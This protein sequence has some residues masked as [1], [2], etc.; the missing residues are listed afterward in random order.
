MTIIAH[1]FS[2]YIFCWP[3][4]NLTRWISQGLILEPDLYDDLKKTL[5]R[6]IRVL[7]SFR[8]MD[9]SLLLGIHNISLNKQ[10]TL[11]SRKPNLETR[12]YSDQVKSIVLILQGSCWA[13]VEQ[14]YSFLSRLPDY[15]QLPTPV[16][17]N[18]SRLWIIT[19]IRSE[20]DE[21]CEL[22]LVTTI[23]FQEIGY[24]QDY[25]KQVLDRIGSK[26]L[27]DNWKQD[28]SIPQ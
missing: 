5:E 12:P 24:D 9:Y 20:F 25:A 11:K 27:K 23:D 28:D 2:S 19:I 4:N 3:R 1:E 7:E 17:S 22:T 18:F 16:Q 13:T 10:E 8:I 15:F 21:L 14:R 26:R 6:D